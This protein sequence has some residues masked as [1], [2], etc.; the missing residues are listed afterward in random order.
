VPYG[1]YKVNANKNDGVWVTWTGYD[2]NKYET[3]KIDWDT[4][5]KKTIVSI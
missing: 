3:K 1:G 5:K 4:L 2:G